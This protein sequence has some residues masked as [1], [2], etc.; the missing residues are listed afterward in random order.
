SARIANG[1]CCQSEVQ[2]WQFFRKRSDIVYLHEVAPPKNARQV[3]FAAA[4]QPNANDVD[5]HVR[6]ALNRFPRILDQIGSI[7]YVD[8]RRLAIGDDKN[9]LAMGCLLA[10]FCCRL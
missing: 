7:R 5:A 4:T 10:N 8:V 2:H 9:E 1:S 6:Y 3:F